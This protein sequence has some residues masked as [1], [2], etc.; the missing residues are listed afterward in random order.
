MEEIAKELGIKEEGTYS[1]D[2]SYV[3]TLTDSDDFGK[4][5]SILNGNDEVEDMNDNAL[6]QDLGASLLYRYGDT[7][8]NLI[9]DLEGDSY[10][11]V[12]TEI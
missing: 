8:I 10:R 9:A 1:R 6:V 11:I 12:M 3:I 7:Q 2:G 5:F 4:V